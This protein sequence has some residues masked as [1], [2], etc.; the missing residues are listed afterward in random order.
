MSR[1]RACRSCVVTVTCEAS[2][3]DVSESIR[4]SSCCRR[5]PTFFTRDSSSAPIFCCDRAC[6]LWRVA[7]ASSACSYRGEANTDRKTIIFTE[8]HRACNSPPGKNVFRRLGIDRRPLGVCRKPTETGGKNTMAYSYP[9][10]YYHR[11]K[12]QRLQLDYCF[13][14]TSRPR[15]TWFS[16]GTLSSTNEKRPQSLMTQSNANVLKFD[17]SRQPREAIPATLADNPETPGCGC[18]HSSTN[19]EVHAY[20]STTTCTACMD[21]AYPIM[22][23]LRP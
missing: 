7:N 22:H 10:S 1:R 2:S 5:S 14:S 16:L 17:Q 6:S 9:Y 3:C 20:T 18:Q 12:C 8:G 11:S 13:P 23:I 15:A 21:H 19:L 4:C